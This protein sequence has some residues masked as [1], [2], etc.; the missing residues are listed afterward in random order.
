MSSNIDGYPITISSVSIV[1]IVNPALVNNEPISFISV[2]GDICGA[3]P[4]S[5]SNS[6]NCNDPLME[7][8]IKQ[9]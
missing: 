3:I 5:L 7:N 8:R 9:E 6:A 4:P 1:N 2:K